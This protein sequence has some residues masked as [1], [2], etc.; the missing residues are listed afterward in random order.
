VRTELHF[1]ALHHGD[2]GIVGRVVVCGCVLN[3]RQGRRNSTHTDC[4][5][6]GYFRYI[7]QGKEDIFVASAEYS[8]VSEPTNYHRLSVC[9]LSPVF[10]FP[11]L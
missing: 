5:N 9:F 8:M 11:G 7:K 2:Y 3:S 4:V 6:V 1:S 10:L